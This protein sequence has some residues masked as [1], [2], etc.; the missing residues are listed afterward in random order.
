MDYKFYRKCPADWVA[1]DHTLAVVAFFFWQFYSTIAVLLSL[2]LPSMLP[3]TCAKTSKATQIQCKKEVNELCNVQKLQMLKTVNDVVLEYSASTGKQE[4]TAQQELFTMEC[5]SCR[6][7][8]MCACNKIIVR[9]RRRH[10]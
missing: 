1:K 8:T 2:Y 6:K 3:A 9:I 7:H 10:F 5:L 4:N